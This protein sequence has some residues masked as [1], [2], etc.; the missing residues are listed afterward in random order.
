MQGSNESHAYAY[1]SCRPVIV[2]ITD[3][4]SQHS[5]VTAV[6]LGRR[7]QA[8]GE[9]MLLLRQTQQPHLIEVPAA[10]TDFSTLS[11]PIESDEGKLVVERL[12]EAAQLIAKALASLK[13]DQ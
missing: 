3:P 10:D 1:A 4:T 8:D 2:T 9:T 7:H 12:L 11:E 13:K 6:L 5:G